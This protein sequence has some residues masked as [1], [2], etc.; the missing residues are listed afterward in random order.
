MSEHTKAQ[1][2]YE[3]I[4]HLP[5]PVSHRHPPMSHLDRAAQFAPFA[6]LSGHDRALE[7]AARITQP[8]VELTEERKQELDRLLRT[9][10]AFPSPPRVT[11]V[12]FVPDKKKTGGTY[13]STTGHLIRLDAAGR[14]LVLSQDRRIPL[15][16]I[17][18]MKLF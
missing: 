2:S 1:G 13:Q 9:A 17:C 7:E 15:D 5:H 3:D 6:A 14:A 18:D 8:P 12:H 16:A 10:L 4:I 11:V